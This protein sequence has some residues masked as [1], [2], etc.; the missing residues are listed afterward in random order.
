VAD[1]DWLEHLV[2]PLAGGASWAGGFYRV[3]ADSAVGEAIGLTLV[4]V[5][6]EVDGG[7]F[8]PSARSMAFTVEAWQRVGGFP[9]HLDYAEDTAFDEAMYAAGLSASF[10]PAAVV[11]WVPPRRPTALL[12]T[13]FRWGKGDGVA[14]LRSSHYRR[15]LGRWATVGVV[16]VAAAFVDVRLVPIAV[17][18]LAPAA[19]RETRHKYRHARRPLTKVLLPIAQTAASLASGLG[20]I[21]G[22]LQR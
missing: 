2:A 1:A 16:A 12:T 20:F 18:P 10:V 17:L 9:E 15:V 22:R 11:S 19:V 3:A 21:R 13:A 4:P 14:G 5:I 7:R 8:L 6:E